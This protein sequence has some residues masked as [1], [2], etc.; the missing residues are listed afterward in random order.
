MLL[1]AVANDG[2]RDVRVMGAID[3]GMVRDAI[4]PVCRDLLVRSDQHDLDD[5]T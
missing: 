1:S 3:D 5:G 2:T 4:K